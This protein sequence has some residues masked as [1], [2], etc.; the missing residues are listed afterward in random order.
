MKSYYGNVGIAV[1]VDFVAVCNWLCHSCSDGG[2]QVRATYSRSTC[3]KVGHL[4]IG[5]PW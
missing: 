2:H 3:T 1:C 5:F 4:L